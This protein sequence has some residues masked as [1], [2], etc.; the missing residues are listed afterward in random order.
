MSIE[1]IALI[2]LAGV[3]VGV[4]LVPALTHPPTHHY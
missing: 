1:T 2:F 4:V 3:L